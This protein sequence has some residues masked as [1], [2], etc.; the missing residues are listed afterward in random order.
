MEGGPGSANNATAP[1]NEKNRGRGR[2]LVSF[3]RKQDRL[4]I[5]VGEYGRK[6]WYGRGLRVGR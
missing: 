3:W 4:A 1:W 2:P 6:L 5:S